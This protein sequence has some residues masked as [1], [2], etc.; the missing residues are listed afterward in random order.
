VL[1]LSN[2]GYYDP[3]FFS[4]AAAAAVEGLGSLEVWEVPVV[5]TALAAGF[6]AAGHY[7]EPLFEALAARVGLGEGC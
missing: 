5:A 2:A 6:S 3:A 4:E 7:E 1:A